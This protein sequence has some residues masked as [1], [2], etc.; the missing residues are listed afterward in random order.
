MYFMYLVE[1]S[2]TS[3]CSFIF[4]YYFLFAMALKHKFCWLTVF[5]VF[6]ELLGDSMVDYAP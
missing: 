3:F 4:L 1:F 5:M 2:L 6:M